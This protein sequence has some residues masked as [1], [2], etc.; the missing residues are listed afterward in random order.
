M[1]LG[2]LGRDT[3]MLWGG[4]RGG[5]QAMEGA[6]WGWRCLWRPGR[7]WGAVALGVHLG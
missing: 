2:G 3:E 6:S 5:R 7:Q 1:E 4:E